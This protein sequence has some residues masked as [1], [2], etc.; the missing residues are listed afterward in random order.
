[1]Y[2]IIFA[3]LVLH[4]KLGFLNF[5]TLTL[6]DGKFFVMRSCS[7]YFTIFSSIL[8]SIPSLLMKAENISR[9]GQL[10]LG[11]KFLPVE[12]HCIK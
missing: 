4:F 2:V 1:M 6:G 7:V 12:N 9:H 11:T 3:L 5:T 10:S 8:V